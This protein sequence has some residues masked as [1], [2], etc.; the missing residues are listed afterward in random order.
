MT[1]ATLRCS[2]FKLP[3]TAERMRV[4]KPH[5][6]DMRSC[7]GRRSAL[8]EGIST[9]VG[10]SFRCRLMNSRSQ[11]FNGARELVPTQTHARI[12][13]ARRFVSIIPRLP[14]P[15]TSGSQPCSCRRRIRREREHGTSPQMER[16]GRMS[17]LESQHARTYVR[18]MTA[19]AVK[20][21]SGRVKDCT[22]R[23]F[24]L[25]GLRIWAIGRPLV[26]N[27][28]RNDFQLVAALPGG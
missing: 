3:A 16:L 20:A 7:G 11:N 6:A 13:P 15:V 26:I 10:R 5:A 14:A 12:Q 18:R 23:P 2:S 4:A 22:T 24:C 17:R 19:A 21:G 25:M 9:R 27:R 1:V 8:I 28:F